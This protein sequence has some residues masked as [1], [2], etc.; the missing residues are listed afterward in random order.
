MTEQAVVASPGTP[1]KPVH[2]PEPLVRSVRSAKIQARHLERSAIV[3]VRQSSQIQVLEHAESKARQYALADQAVA[4]GWRTE[5]VLVIDEDQGKSGKRADHRTGFQQLLAEVT[6][7]HVGLV[8]G[9]EMSRLARSSK[10]W[11]HLLELCALFGVLLG[12]QDGVYNPIDS[13]DRLLLGL[14][15][16]MSE[17]ELFTMRNRLQRGI[18]HKAERC[19]MHIAPPVG[20]QRLPSG[21]VVLDTDEQARDIVQLVFDKFDELGGARKVMIYLVQHG[22]QLGIRINRGSRCGTLVWRR[23]NPGIIWRILTHPIYAGA[24]VFGRKEAEPGQVNGKYRRY[25]KRYSADAWKILLK[26]R[27]P[28]YISWERYEANQKRLKDNRSTITSSGVPRDGGAML[29]GIVICGTCGRRFRCHH[30]RPEHPYYFCARDTELAQERTCHGLAARVVDRLVINQ[31]QEA[32]KPAALKLSL[33]AIEDSQKER[34]R[35]EA[36]WKKRLERARYEADRAERQYQA[37]EPENRLVAR[38]LEQRWETTLLEL[39]CLQDDYDRFS[40]EKPRRVTEVQRARIMAL[41]QDIPTLWDAESTTNADRK[42]ILRCVIDQVV[43]RV[44]QNTERCDVTIQWKGGFASQ[45]EIIRPVQSR[46]QM[47]DE[48]RLRERITQLKLQG[49]TAAS[50]A[51]TLVAD[52]FVTT[53]QRGDYNG[54]IVRA[55]MRRYGL[56]KIR[57]P[58]SL[59]E[60]E[61]RLGELAKRLGVSSRKLRSWV[62][63]KWCHARRTENDRWIV[64]ADRQE[65]HRLRQLAS[66]STRGA[67]NYPATM[68]TPRTRN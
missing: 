2:A 17:F 32:L 18:W 37:V 20:Y 42:E 6:L 64:W 67:N 50:I 47:Q 16:T 61:W 62:L 13:N 4:L 34:D 29:A 19:E 63:C 27:M 58:G 59:L 60:N 56:A 3:Y 8:L 46:N 57:L 54:D 35:L 22:I 28:A 14:K 55:L 68:T 15:G 9:L 33:R 21:E 12:D 26:D 40:R 52:G 38:T 36:H 25:Q 45:H 39:R 53:R 10:D 7:G 30:P 5:K 48:D 43:V 11:H 44:E 66:Q 41:A 23:P 65:I 51:A 24:Y 49:K 1:D 31:V